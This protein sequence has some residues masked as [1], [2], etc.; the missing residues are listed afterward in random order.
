[1]FIILYVCLALRSISLDVV[2]S[3]STNSLLQSLKRHCNLHGI[4]DSI[5]TDNAKQFLASKTYLND[6]LSSDDYKEFLD[7]HSITH[8]TIPS[9]GSWYGAIYERSVGTTKRNLYKTIGRAKL[10]YFELITHLSDIQNMIN[11]RPLTYVHSEIDEIHALTP[12]MVIKPHAN[13][14]LVYNVDSDPDP[15]WIPESERNPTHE[16]I[17]RTLAKQSKLFLDFQ[18]RW[19]SDYLLSLRESTRDVFQTGFENK[20][21]VGTFVSLTHLIKLE[22]T[23]A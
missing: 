6:A 2:S 23:G 19:Y 7:D 1:M 18:R 16:E 9:Y 13:P 8:K 14:R 4:P 3:M 20:V 11:N 17:N 12:N 10:T 22:Y 21:R 5:Y 15:M